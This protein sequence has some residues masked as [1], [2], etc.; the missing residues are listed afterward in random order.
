MRKLDLII[1]KWYFELPLTHLN[2]KRKTLEMAEL[3]FQ[4]DFLL[5]NPLLYAD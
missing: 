5:Q 1:S 4:V 3:P 2:P